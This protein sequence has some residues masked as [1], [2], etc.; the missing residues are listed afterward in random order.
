MHMESNNYNPQHDPLLN[1]FREKLGRHSMPVGPAV[2]E[3]LQSKLPVRKRAIPL[4]LIVS[5]SVAAAVALLFTVGTFFFLLNE[6][7]ADESLIVMVEESEEQDSSQIDVLIPENEELIHVEPIFAANHKIS[8]GKA[9]SS[10]LMSDEVVLSEVLIAKSENEEDVKS[11]E[12]VNQMLAEKEFATASARSAASEITTL[13]QASEDWT[14]DL[15]E[16]KDRNIQVAAGVGSGVAGTSGFSRGL[17]YDAGAMSE[18]FESLDSRSNASLLAPA[19]FSSRNYLPPLTVGFYVRWPLNEKVSF[20]TGIQYSYLLTRMFSTGW[21]NA[22]AQLHLHYIGV[23][24]NLVYSLHRQGKW[25]VYLSGGAA[26]DKGVWSD[27][28]QQQTWGSATVNTNATAKIQ[29][30]QPSLNASLGIGY[31]FSDEM[32]L[33]IDPR[34]SYYFPN[35]QPF[36]IRTEMPLLIGINAGLRMNL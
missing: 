16:K 35:D 27:Y 14:K 21:T 10:I 7:L 30:Y 26:F 9:S 25:D 20:E 34:L 28:R 31:R 12:D 8:G 15:L 5:T 17:L 2:W 19:D 23:P 3:G 24:L 32:S 13:M 29:G 4:W 6:T 33:Y 22:S 11:D 18:R 36:S 1:E